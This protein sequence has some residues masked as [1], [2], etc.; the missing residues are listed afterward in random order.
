MSDEPFLKVEVKNSDGEVA[1]TLTYAGYKTFMRDCAD[2]HFREEHASNV[3][4]V[5]RGGKPFITAIITKVP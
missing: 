3:L 5:T 4:V 1:K 2:P